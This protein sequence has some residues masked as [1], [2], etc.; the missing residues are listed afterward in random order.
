[1]NSREKTEKHIND[2]KDYMRDPWSYDIRCLRQSRG[3]TLKQAAALIG[4]HWE[5]ISR[6]ENERAM[7]DEGTQKRYKEMLEAFD[8]GIGKG[9]HNKPCQCCPY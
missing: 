9:G 5:T 3:L 2:A 1:M 7:P 8:H 6:W 4:S